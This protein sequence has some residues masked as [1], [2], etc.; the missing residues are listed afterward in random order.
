MIGDSTIGIGSVIGGYKLEKEIGRGG[1]GVVY[2]A[3]EMSLNR[4]VALKLLSQRLCADTEFVERFKR[5]ARIIAALNHPNVVQ[6]LSYGET[7]GIYYFAMEYI[8]GRDLGV[9]LKEK[10][11]IPLQEALGIVSQVASALADAGAKGVVHR[12]LKPSNIM[13]DDLGRVKVTDFGVAHFEGT[14]SRLTQT[15]LFL[16]TP[17]Y[18]SPE[19]ALGKDLDVR[20]DIYA[21]GAVLYSMISGRPPIVGPSPLAVVAKI[22]TEAITPIRQIN[23]ELPRPVCDLIDKMLAKNLEDRYQTPREVM[24]AVNQC[25]GNIKSDTPTIKGRDTASL[26]FETP[27]PRKS[28]AAVWGG[29]LG[30]A[31]AV[32]LVVWAVEGS[33]FKERSK[34]KEEK[35]AVEKVVPAKE[36]EPVVKPP[37]EKAVEKPAEPVAATPPAVEVVDQ[38][39]PVAVLPAPIP[40]PQPSEPPPAVIPEKVERPAPEPAPSGP[41]RQLTARVPDTVQQPLP[42]RAP[43]PKKMQPSLPSVPKVLLAFSGD[44]M[45]AEQVQPYLESI[46]VG[47]GLTVSSREVHGASS[48]NSIKQQLRPGEVQILVL[49]KVRQTG[50]MNLQYYGRSQELITASFSASAVDMESGVSVAAP[51]TASVQFTSLNMAEKFR[52][53]VSSSASGLGGA[54]R[55]YWRGKINDPG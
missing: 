5:E 51:A 49:V 42:Q 3:H 12:D 29:V 27:A 9:I 32:V 45:M 33:F 35:P 4:K 6:I 36:S 18:A 34:P 39:P 8:T 52:S 24:D 38:K 47:S 53:A 23:P 17:E 43:A 19:Q 22:A 50:S 15:G 25:L 21:L 48:W 10:S 2:K 28:R 13:V 41:G 46:L 26:S 40:S 1:M 37:V 54:I 31:L 55:Q 30:V 20:S 44:E 14:E 7:Q 16:G 11:R